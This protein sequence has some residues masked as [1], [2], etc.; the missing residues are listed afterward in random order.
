LDP[1]IFHS[2]WT[3]VLM[4]LFVGIV[5]WAWSKNRKSSFDMAA[6]VPLEDDETPGLPA[7][8]PKEEQDG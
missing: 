1:T 3:I 7:S 2:L 5:I 4:V 6:R 8:T